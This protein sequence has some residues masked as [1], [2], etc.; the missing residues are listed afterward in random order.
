MGRALATAPSSAGSSRVHGFS[1][2]EVII[3]MS[4]LTIVLMLLS[5]LALSSG[6]RARMN[7][8]TTKRNFALAQQAGRIEVMPF[9][10]VALLTSGT[11]QMLVGDFTFNRRLVVTATGTTRYTIRIVVEPLAGEFRPD[12]VT[13]DRT[14][15]ASGSP[16]CT[17]C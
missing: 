4:L 3:A 14:R 1:L 9:T 5:T 17:T 15:P 6:R 13:I 12:S 2:I 11:T 7:D 8:L 16:L 10:D